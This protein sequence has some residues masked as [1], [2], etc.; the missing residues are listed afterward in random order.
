VQFAPGTTGNGKLERF[1][2]LLSGTRFYP[3]LRV[4]ICH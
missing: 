2:R 3:L 4:G 1:P